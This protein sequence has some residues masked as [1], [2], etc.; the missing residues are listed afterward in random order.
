MNNWTGIGN[1]GSDPKIVTFESGTKKAAFSLATPSYRKDK[2]GNK[3]TD[4][5][6]IVMIGNVVDVVE[7]YVKKGSKI[8]LGGGEIQYRNYTNKDG[9]KVYITEVLC[10]ELELLDKKPTSQ[11]QPKDNQ[12]KWQGKK[13]VKAMSSTDEL[14]GNVDD[15]N[16]PDDDQMSDLP[17]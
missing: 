12:G 5:H 3:V 6:S 2:E 8:G 16:I 10:R 7:K 17:F 14:P 11:P 13:E 9:Q 1:V 4:W 15:G